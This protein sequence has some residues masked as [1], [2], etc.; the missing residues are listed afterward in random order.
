MCKIRYI[1]RSDGL[2]KTDQI[3]KLENRE[4][5]IV[6]KPYYIL[7]DDNAHL[8]VFTF[9]YLGVNENTGIKEDNIF[10]LKYGTETGRLDSLSV[11][12]PE[13]ERVKLEFWTAFR[14]T[15]SKN[16]SSE[17]LQKLQESFEITQR[18]YFDKFDVVEDGFPE[19]Q[20]TAS[21]NI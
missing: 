1:H 4:F 10:C 13:N 19:S 9:Y 20:E 17:V 7:R 16:D 14:K 3:I 2:V 8:C 6:D 18:I 5:D 11:K 21:K 12:V 15:I